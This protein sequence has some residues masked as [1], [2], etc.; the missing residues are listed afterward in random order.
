LYCQNSEPDTFIN[1]KF[2]LEMLDN[3]YR[4]AKNRYREMLHKSLNYRGEEALEVK[5]AIGK[6]SIWIRK[7]FPDLINRSKYM[8]KEFLKEGYASDSEID[9][10]IQGL[11]KKR[12]LT[13]PN[14]IKARKFAIEQLKSRGYSIDEIA[15]YMEISRSTVYNIIR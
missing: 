5:K 9:G 7:N 13:R 11:R 12:R 3:D 6:F 2:I 8:E 15:E 4:A 10:I 1:W 14:D